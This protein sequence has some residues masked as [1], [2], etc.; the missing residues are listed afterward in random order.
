MTILVDLFV[1]IIDFCSTLYQISQLLNTKKRDFHLS[2][3]SWTVRKVIKC[4]EY[5]NF[6]NIIAIKHHH[7]S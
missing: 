4:F 2:S 6:H 3:N 5:Y 1:E 7:F